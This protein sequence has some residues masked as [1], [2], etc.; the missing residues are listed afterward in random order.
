MIEADPQLT[1]EQRIFS[2]LDIVQTKISR[3]GSINKFEKSLPKGPPKRRAPVQEQE[4][5]QL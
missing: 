5:D 4:P 2:A 3:A 1:M